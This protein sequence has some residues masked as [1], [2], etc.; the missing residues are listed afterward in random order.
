MVPS[1]HMC[2]KNSHATK[3]GRSYRTYTAA[4]VNRL[5]FGSAIARVASQ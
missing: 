3:T 2:D 4:A 1:L 5:G